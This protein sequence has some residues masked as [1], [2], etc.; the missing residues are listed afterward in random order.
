MKQENDFPRSILVE[1]TL[2]CPADCIFC[3]NKKITGRP[4]DMPWELFRHIVDDCRDR[5]VEECH[6]F[7]NGEPLA[8]PYLEDALVYIGM[9]HIIQ[10]IQLQR[11]IHMIKREP[12]Q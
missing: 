10:V 4:V 11:A 7:I 8:L 3:P 12:I 6:P 1:T 9:V 5:G 2:R